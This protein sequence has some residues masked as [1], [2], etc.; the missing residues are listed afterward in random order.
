MEPLEN[1]LPGAVLELFREETLTLLYGGNPRGLFPGGNPETPCE[2][3]E[4]SFELI[5][6]NPGIGLLGR[7]GGKPQ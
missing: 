3:Q 5:L 2:R 4:S 7:R 6:E 1:P